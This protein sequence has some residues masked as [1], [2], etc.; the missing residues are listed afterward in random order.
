MVAIVMNLLHG[1]QDI[2]RGRG[3]PTLCTYALHAHPKDAEVKPQKIL[4]PK[5]SQRQTPNPTS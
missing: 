3:R 4:N 5:K 1:T 2:G